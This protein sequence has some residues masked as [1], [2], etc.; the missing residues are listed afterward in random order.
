M[1]AISSGLMP[2]SDQSRA[3]A[4]RSAVSSDVAESDLIESRKTSSPRGALNVLRTLNV[5]RA[6]SMSLPSQGGSA[7]RQ[8]MLLGG[9]KILLPCGVL[10][11]NRPSSDYVTSDAGAAHPHAGDYVADPP[12]G[13]SAF[14]HELVSNCDGLIAATKEHLGRTHLESM[15]DR[16]FVRNGT[17]GPCSALC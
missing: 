15:L 17:Q 9:E 4:S 8:P 3:S 6:L 14:S 1:I 7:L 12:N 2:P 16:L 5:A 13:Y 10:D 11:Q